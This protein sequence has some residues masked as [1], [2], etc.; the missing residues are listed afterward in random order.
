MYYFDRP[1]TFFTNCVRYGLITLAFMTSARS[2]AVELPPIL[3]PSDYAIERAKALGGQVFKILPL[4]MNHPAMK[5]F[6][7]GSMARGV[8]GRGDYYKFTEGPHRPPLINIVFH[9]GELT[10]SS[11]GRNYGL[12]ADLRDRDLRDI[13]KTLTEA[14][15]VLSYRP[16][17]MQSDIPGERKR[18]QNVA[19]TGS[20]L[21]LRVAAKVGHT[22]LLR[23]ICFDW[24]DL[25]VAL[26][27]F[28]ISADGSMTVIWKKLEEFEVPPSL[29][30][31]DAEL[32]EKVHEVLAELKV[33]DLQV[34][35]EDNV[36]KF[37]GSDRNFDRVKAALSERKIPYRGIGYFMQRSVN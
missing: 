20:G 3:R 34:T 8:L 16:P 9:R 17:R 36:L 5:G 18:L 4:E 29:F 22:Y 37:T 23:S 13:N 31:A 28:D 33:Q 12:F 19:S 21:T 15:P 24:A 26:H 35:V 6:N 10:V 27:I 1:H 32:Q 7:Q 11:D 2:Q 25:A 30:M 14:Q